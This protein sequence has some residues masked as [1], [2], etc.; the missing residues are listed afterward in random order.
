[1]SARPV[2]E[3]TL[4]ETRRALEAGEVV[5]DVREPIEYAAGHL[6]GAR[7][8]PSTQL[9]QRLWEV[10]RGV[11]VH[12][13]CATGDRS[14]EEAAWL[15]AVGYDAVSCTDGLRGWRPEDA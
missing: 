15:R 11:R 13:V 6:A 4:A 2:V 14:R 9:R 7:S 3:V 8:L 5:I 10:P 12:L 1:M